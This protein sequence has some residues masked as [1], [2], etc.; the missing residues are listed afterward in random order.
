MILYTL[1]CAHD[2]HFEQWFDNSGD[3]DAKKTAG[4]L[5]CPECGERQVD[6]AI[7]APNVGRSAAAAPAP[8]PA[9]ACT[10]MG[11]GGCQF[12]GQH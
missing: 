3:F 6:K 2:H 11:C 4:E 9:P 12:A 7:M 5:V 8:A 1:R 10:P